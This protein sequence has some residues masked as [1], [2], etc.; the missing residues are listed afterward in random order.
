MPSLSLEIDWIGAVDVDVIPYLSSVLALNDESVSGETSDIAVCQTGFGWGV[1][2]HV[3]A[4][5]K[6]ENPATNKPFYTTSIA[7]AKVYESG[8]QPLSECHPCDNTGQLGTCTKGWQQIF[9]L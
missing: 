2:V 1:D 8:L 6:L 5:I 4:D 7:R 9:D 3:G